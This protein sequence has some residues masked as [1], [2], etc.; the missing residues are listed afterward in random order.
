MRAKGLIKINANK[1]TVVPSATLSK[2]LIVVAN[3]IDDYAIMMVAI[4]GGEV[5]QLVEA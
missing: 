3:E 2:K 1:V 4:A 5:T